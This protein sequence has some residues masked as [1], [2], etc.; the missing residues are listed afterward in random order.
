MLKVFFHFFL[1]SIMTE[2]QIAAQL[3]NCVNQSGN[4]AEKRRLLINIP[5]I[6]TA[7]AQEIYSLRYLPER[8]TVFAVQDP[9]LREIFAPNFR[10]RLVQHW[11]VSLVN[12]Q[13]S[14]GWIDDC[15]SNRSGKGTHSA[16]ARLQHF[17]R[18]PHNTYFC[19]MDIASYFPSIDRSILL[20]LWQEQFA[21]LDYPDQTLR[22]IEA[23]AVKIILQNPA[24]PKPLFSG[25]RSLLKKIPLNKS[26][27]YN[28]TRIGLPIG[29]LS[30]QFFSNLYLNPLD[31]FIRH[32][33]KISAY[34]R[35]V[36][37]FIILGQ[38]LETL[39][40]QKKRIHQFLGSHLHLQLHPNKTIL[41]KVAQG[42][43]F[44]GYIVYPHHCYIRER[45]LRA[46]K[47]RIYF[48]S[49]LLDPVRYPSH[50]MPTGGSWAKWLALHQLH[51][52]LAVNP[53]L[54]LRMLGTI[55]SYYGQ[56]IHANSY[57]L[58]RTIYHELLGPLKRY[59][60]PGDATYAKLRIKAVWLRPLP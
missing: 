7:L 40:E 4:S 44:L 58:R 12:P 14:R 49:S 56:L 1:V 30:S 39:L 31:Q 22:Q 48:F 33:L 6:V 2:A 25:E 9:K 38:N 42:A 57:Q 32:Q 59:L 21:R 35:Y 13:I 15:Y 43:N 5:R 16:I 52:P 27:F 53:T 41:Q 17:M 10:D 19:Q 55:N 26:L 51:P 50:G 28:P 8:M 11:L 24:D 45:T 37:D 20:S 47:K 34:L 36:D 60:L 54:L 29:S 23:V 18:R 46:L 3:Y